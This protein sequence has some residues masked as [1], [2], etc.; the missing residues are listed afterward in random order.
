MLLLN[1]NR[2]SYML[3]PIPPSCKKL[4]SYIA[5][6]LTM[7]THRNTL[8]WHNPSYS[9][10]HIFCLLCRFVIL[11]RYR[12]QS[13]KYRFL[14]S[15]TCIFLHG[16][17]GRIGKKDKKNFQKYFLHVVVQ[18]CRKQVHDF[19]PKILAQKRT[20]AWYY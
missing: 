14:D 13:K 11:C 5:P 12:A 3:S 18:G 4:S 10:K 17:S 20:L 2:K 6:H 19:M 9:P 7:R 16:C 8:S 15:K 1:T